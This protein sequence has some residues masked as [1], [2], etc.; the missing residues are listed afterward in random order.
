MGDKTK[1]H[2]PKPPGRD[3]V[4]Y[5]QARTGSGSGAAASESNGTEKKPSGAETQPSSSETKPSST[6]TQPSGA[7]TQ[8]S[9]SETQPSSP[10]AA[11]GGGAYVKVVADEAV[12]YYEVLSTN[13]AK[14][15]YAVDKDLK[16]PISA[17][18]DA[19]IEL[20]QGSTDATV[21][22]RWVSD[23]QEH[24]LRFGYR[25]LF[26]TS[27]GAIPQECKADGSFGARTAFIVRRFQIHASL[28]HREV[29]GKVVEVTPTFK[30]TVNGIV[31]DETKK[32][33]K[34][35]LEKKYR[36]VLRPFDPEKT[37]ESQLADKKLCPEFV[38]KLKTDLVAQADKWDIELYGPWKGSPD[39]DAF[40]KT[41]QAGGS[42]HLVGLALDVNHYGDKAAEGTY[43]GQYKTDKAPS[44]F[45]HEQRAFEAVA[46]AAGLC[47]AN[48]ISKDP[49]HVEYHPLLSGTST[50]WLM[51]GTHIKFV[52]HAVGATDND[53][54]KAW[55]MAV[56]KKYLPPEQSESLPAANAPAGAAGP[57]IP[58]PPTASG[59]AAPK[60]HP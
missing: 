20:K 52:K 28:K 55:G 56:D 7:E 18:T 58:K 27:T 2:P 15:T 8:P 25:A 34:L 6:G 44:L 4:A 38:T 49:R 50:T 29:D 46:H 17:L 14:Y 9:S 39:P 37:L 35:W 13:K 10:G 32:E 48:P 5:A 54:L 24:L 1:P 43:Q 3:A 11:T 33:I 12:P 22:F 26:M 42:W 41:H 57:A 45:D 60:K 23:L 59:A 51:F 53:I 31:D 30:G 40:R 21:P 36:R 47:T 19:E 16:K